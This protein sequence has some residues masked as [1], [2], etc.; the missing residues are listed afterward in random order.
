MLYKNIINFTACTYCRSHW[1]RPPLFGPFNFTHF[2]QR[3]EAWR[4][5]ANYCKSSM[6]TFAIDILGFTPLSLSLS[7]FLF[8]VVRYGFPSSSCIHPSNEA[9]PLQANDGRF[10]FVKLSGWFH[11]LRHSSE[12]LLRRPYTSVSCTHPQFSTV[13]S[14]EGTQT[15]ARRLSQ[16]QTVPRSQIFQTSSSLYTTLLSPIPFI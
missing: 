16:D 6:P 15:F 4:Q 9:L 14:T 7:P 13:H 5:T 12:N 8:L 11:A 2:G 1:G 10:Q 3:E